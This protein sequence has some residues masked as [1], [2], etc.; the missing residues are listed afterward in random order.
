MTDWWVIILQFQGAFY[1]P[2]WTL[3]E[4]IFRGGRQ[5]FRMGQAP[6]GPTV[7]RPLIVTPGEEPPLD[8]Y[9][10]DNPLG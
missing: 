2:P 8:A 1:K 9:P 6:S 7:I 10:G 4:Q 3:S 5:V